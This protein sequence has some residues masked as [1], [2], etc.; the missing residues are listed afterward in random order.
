M[1]AAVESTFLFKHRKKV[2][3]GGEKKKRCRV[4]KN[5][6]E[7]RAASV[8][9]LS[10]RFHFGGKLFEESFCLMMRERCCRAT[11]SSPS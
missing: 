11:P 1:M 7:R 5:W 2:S 8:D 4:P 10:R 6:K 9:F 3:L